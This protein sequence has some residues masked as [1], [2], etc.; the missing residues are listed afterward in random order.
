MTPRHYIK[1]RDA[2]KNRGFTID[3]KNQF[4]SLENENKGHLNNNEL[5]MTQQTNN[6]LRDNRTMTAKNS[7]E[8]FPSR[9]DPANNNF[10]SSDVENCINNTRRPEKKE[11]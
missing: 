11:C 6:N 3:T 10:V 8:I 7:N 5:N 2:R 1:N 4:Q 9:T